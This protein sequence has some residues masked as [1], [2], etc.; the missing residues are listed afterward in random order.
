MTESTYESVRPDSTN[1]RMMAIATTK[2]STRKSE[3]RRL[4]M[5]ALISVEPEPRA[6]EA[7]LECSTDAD[8]RDEFEP[9]DLDDCDCATPDAT[10]LR[11]DLR[12]A[13]AVL[14]APA[15]C[16][17]PVGAL[18]SELPLSCSSMP[19]TCTAPP[20]TAAPIASTSASSSSSSSSSARAADTPTLTCGEN[21]PNFL[22]A[23]ATTAA[24]AAAAAA[25]WAF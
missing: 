20:P 4:A 19:S 2:A 9:L 7:S 14:T 18:K 13:G 1:S 24:A 16:S 5:P 15:C 17:D 6:N 21:L 11:L 23:L 22:G 3:R 25:A 8:E 12:A 10:A